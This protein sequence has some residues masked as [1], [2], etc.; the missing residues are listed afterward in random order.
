V[1]IVGPERYKLSFDPKK[2]N[3]TCP[4]GTAKFSGLATSKLP[5]LYIVAVD[6]SM[7]ELLGRR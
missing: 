2:C 1:K 5:K 4:K 7:L 3:V 6:G